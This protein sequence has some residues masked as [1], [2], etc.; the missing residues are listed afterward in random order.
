MEELHDVGVELKDY[1]AGLIDLRTALELRGFDNVDEIM[2]RV[3]PVDLAVALVADPGRARVARGHRDLGHDRRV[4][5]LIHP[6]RPRRPPG[7]AG[8]EA[9]AR[10]QQ[11][12]RDQLGALFA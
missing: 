12:E 5:R 4:H 6:Q 1:E 3:E 2:E 8:L 11:A 7:P 9:L 10:L